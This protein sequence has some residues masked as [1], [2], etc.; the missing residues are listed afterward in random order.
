[1]RELYNA[2]TAIAAHS[3]LTSV[4]IEIHH[5]KVIAGPVLQVYQSVTTDTK[6]AVT[7]AFDQFCISSG[8]AEAAIIYHDKIIAGTLI[9]IKLELHR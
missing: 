8:Q 6:P 7:K 2:A 5:L 4:T 3:A 9:F 1:M